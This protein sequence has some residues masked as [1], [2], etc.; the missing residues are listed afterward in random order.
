MFSIKKNRKMLEKEYKVRRA[1]KDDET[2]E[3]TIPAS[4]RRYHKVKIGEKIKMLADGVII[5]LP[6][7]ASEEREEEV[8][9]FL[10][11]NK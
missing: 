9:N 5:I 1:S 4:W 7:N 6:P 2:A 10:E 8:R 3:V 11:G